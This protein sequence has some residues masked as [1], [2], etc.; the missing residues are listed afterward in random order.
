MRRID[1]EVKVIEIGDP[2]EVVTRDGTTH[3]VATATVTDDSGDIKM[4]LWDDHIDQV[5]VG[6]PIRIENGYST[7]FRNETQLNVGRYGKL[8][9]LGQELEKK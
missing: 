9:I 8:I 7:S 2:R 6:D 4:S 3:R 5:K 1:I